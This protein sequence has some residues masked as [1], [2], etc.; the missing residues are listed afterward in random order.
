MTDMGAITLKLGES[1]N[2][3][4][5]RMLGSLRSIYSSRRL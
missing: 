4:R 2:L 3:L 1:A 5:I